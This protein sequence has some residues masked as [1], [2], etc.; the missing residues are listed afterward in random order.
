M[1]NFLLGIG[2]I[3]GVE[4]DP[5]PIF[6]KLPVSMEGGMGESAMGTIQITYKNMYNCKCDMC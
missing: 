3:W 2:E 1:P 6:V 5:V 4:P